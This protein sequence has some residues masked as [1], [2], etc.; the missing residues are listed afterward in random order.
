MQT[1]LGGKTETQTRPARKTKTL[2]QM[3]KVELQEAATPAE[4]VSIE[5][6]LWGGLDSA[7][8]L[9]LSSAAVEARL[10]EIEAEQKKGEA[11]SD[12]GETS[13]EKR[14]PG[15]APLP[16]PRNQGS[17]PQMGS[18]QWKRSLPAGLEQTSKRAASSSVTVSGE[19][20]IS[21]SHANLTGV[22]ARL[23]NGALRPEKPPDAWSLLRE[24]KEAGVFFN[25]E[26]MREG[27]TEEGEDPELAAAVEETIRLLFGVRGILR[28]GAGKNDRAESI[29]VVV[30]S[31][32]F[33]DASLAS[34]P[35][36]VHRFSTVVAIP[37]ELLPLR[38]DR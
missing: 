29:V 5:A 12:S 4:P 17:S 34:V 38:R 7:K 26:S 25:E 22:S 8:S 36:K 32:G 37:F 19:K 30:A 24:A 3:K 31:H 33:S 10:A 27:H 13:G 18:A 14:E 15:K 23:G 21:A 11:V 2:S 6:A 35:E 16:R 28:V 9:E 1:G 20:A